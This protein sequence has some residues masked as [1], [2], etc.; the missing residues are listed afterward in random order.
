MRASTPSNLGPGGLAGWLGGSLCD[1]L[2]IQRGSDFFG[3][4]RHRRGDSR[5]RWLLWRNSGLLV[6]PKQRGPV[7][8]SFDDMPKQIIEAFLVNVGNVAVQLPVEALGLPKI[9]Q[10]VDWN[11]E[12][13]LDVHPRT[14]RLGPRPLGKAEEW[15]LWVIPLGS[16][17]GPVSVSAPPI[18]RVSLRPRRTPGII[19]PCPMG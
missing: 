1:R 15:P 18:R 10:S 6:P 14:L 12:Y 13:R 2:S 4:R 17:E 11:E 9:T 5:R 8:V 3:L 19:V 16:G 7:P